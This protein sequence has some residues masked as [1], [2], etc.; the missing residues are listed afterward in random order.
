M[1]R[2][3]SW[4]AVVS[5]M[6]AALLM[7]G[8]AG[9]SKMQRVEEG[10]TPGYVTV[11]DIVVYTQGVAQVSSEDMREMTE[12]YIEQAWREQG[13]KYISQRELPTTPVAA[14][15]IAEMNARV[16]FQQGASDIVQ[17]TDARINYDLVRAED[18]FLWKEASAKTTDWSVSQGATVDVQNAVR[19]AAMEA[20]K[21]IKEM[22]EPTEEET[23]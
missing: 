15:N 9:G 18:G 16:T 1:K 2:T 13:V 11:G 23:E 3:I 17:S 10:W 5:L 12:N 4:L 7:S 8:C 14:S 21:D 19:F 22:M 20:A 6:I